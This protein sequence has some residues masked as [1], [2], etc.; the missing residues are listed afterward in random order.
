MM[1]KKKEGVAPGPG[2]AQCSSVGQYQDRK[3]KGVDWG[4]G[5]R[6]RI[7]GTSRAGEL[8]KGEITWNVNKEY[9]K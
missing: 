6:K 4:T 1:T 9:I 8:R 7:Y 2:K 5:G 3:W